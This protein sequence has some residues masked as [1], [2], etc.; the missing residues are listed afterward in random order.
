[1]KALLSACLIFNISQCII[2]PLYDISESFEENCRQGPS[3]FFIPKRTMPDKKQWQTLL[4]YPIASKIGIP[5]CAIMTSKGIAF[6]AKLGFDVLTYKTIRST[7][8]AS[9]QT[10]NVCFVDCDHQ[11]THDE[12]GKTVCSA[13]TIEKYENIALCNSLGNPCGDV[14]WVEKDIAKARACLQEGQVLIVS[15]FGQGADRESIA[16]DYAQTAH[17]AHK[18]GAQIIELN[19]SCPNVIHGF[20]YKDPVMMEAIIKRVCTA[21]HIPVIIKVGVFDSKEQMRTILKT[22]AQAGAQGICGINTVPVC[23]NDSNGKPFFGTQRISSGLSGAPIRNLAKEFIHDA[24]EIIHHENLNLVILAT[25]GITHPDHFQEFIDLGADV[26]QC[27]TATMWNPYLAVDFHH[28]TQK[29]ELIHELYNIGCL[30]TGNFKLKNGSQSPIYLDL[31]TIVSYPAI[32]QSLAQCLWHDIERIQFDVVCGV[33]Y[34]A[35]PM[36]TAVS[37]SLKNQ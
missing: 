14:E 18:A 1:M 10:P 35:L 7:K 2:H 16:H 15:V 37:L 32:L 6:A 19:L 25:G 22:A 26:A 27:A 34:T 13:K 9:Y 33:P 3:D 5:A 17:I 24:Q 4:G 30:K 21:V 11:I 12:I 29:K 36:A 23:V 8:T 31:R 28:N 20:F